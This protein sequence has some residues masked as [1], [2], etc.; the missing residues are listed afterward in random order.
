MSLSV[1]RLIGLLLP[2]LGIIYVLNKRPELI[3]WTIIIPCIV[4]IFIGAVSYAGLA[5]LMGD[6]IRISGKQFAKCDQF[7][8]GSLI[9]L[10]SFVLLVLTCS[11]NQKGK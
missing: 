3:A 11:F 10:L 9:T 1:C 7:L 6:T 2:I 4:F 5:P 8:C